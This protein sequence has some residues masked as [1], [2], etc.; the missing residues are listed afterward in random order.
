VRAGETASA[1]H[2]GGAAIGR[3][4]QRADSTEQATL[5]GQ[6]RTQT[7]RQTGQ[8]RDRARLA[9]DALAVT[10]CATCVPPKLLHSRGSTGPAGG[11]L[12]AAD[13]CRGAPTARPGLQMLARND[14]YADGG[15]MRFRQ[16]PSQL[17][18]LRLSAVSGGPGPT[19]PET[20][21]SMRCF[22]P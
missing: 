13:G 6:G 12:A 4:G 5:D 3:W 19:R 1:S 20:S 2:D 8:G 22:P 10:V 15:Q 7:T 17:S 21:T 11:P 9:K 14:R 18:V 16:G